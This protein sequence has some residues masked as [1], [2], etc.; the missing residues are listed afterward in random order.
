M[1]R[2][3]RV[4][5]GLRFVFNQR[6]LSYLYH[7]MVILFAPFSLNPPLGI[8]E[9]K[10]PWDLLLLLRLG[11]FNQTFLP[12]D[13][14]CAAKARLFAVEDG[15][16]IVGGEDN[17]WNQ[18]PL[19]P[20]RRFLMRNHGQRGS[21]N[22]KCIRIYTCTTHNIYTKAWIKHRLASAH[23]GSNHPTSPSFSSLAAI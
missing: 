7:G 18:F 10:R 19:V 5:L 17:V 2:E 23:S 8:R 20:K 4:S 22:V 13:E 3:R 14:V 21:Q 15:N 11:L 6:H 12:W 16:L 1:R 9:M